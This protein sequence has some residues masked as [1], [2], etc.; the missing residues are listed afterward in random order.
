MPPMPEQNRKSSRTR[1]QEDDHPIMPFPECPGGVA[2]L[3]EKVGYRR[4]VQVHP[5]AARRSAVPFLR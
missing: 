4:L 2:G 3:L 1:G 5:L